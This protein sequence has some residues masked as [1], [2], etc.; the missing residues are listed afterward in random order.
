[1]EVF[2]ANLR[3]IEE[4]AVQPTED[5]PEH[6]IRK[7]KYGLVNLTLVAQKSLRQVGGTE[8]AQGLSWLKVGCK[9]P[10]KPGT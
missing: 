10:C 4:L 1:M 8:H 3:A 6:V 2:T 5:D 7:I 9:V